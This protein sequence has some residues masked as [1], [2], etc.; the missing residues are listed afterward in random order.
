MHPEDLEALIK[1]PRALR[2]MAL[3]RTTAWR[4][5]QD[6]PTFPKAVRIGPHSFAYR[7]RDVHRWI[8]TRQPALKTRSADGAAR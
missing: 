6:D 4:R 3:S 7:V 1:R 8:E 5:E 2:L